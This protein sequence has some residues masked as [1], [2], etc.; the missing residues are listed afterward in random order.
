MCVLIAVHKASLA[1]AE[2]ERI[3]LGPFK[4]L[5]R[6]SNGFLYRLLYTTEHRQLARCPTDSDLMRLMAS[7]ILTAEAYDAYDRLNKQRLW[8]VANHMLLITA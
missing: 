5:S 8:Y 6:T 7:Q 2:V 3:P 1:R 4:V